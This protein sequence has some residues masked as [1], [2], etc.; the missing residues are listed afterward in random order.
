[1]GLLYIY[2]SSKYFAPPNVKM[3]SP[4]LGSRCSKDSWGI[5][6]AHQ[7]LFYNISGQF[8]HVSCLDLYVWGSH[9]CS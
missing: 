7:I 2:W 9:V 5:C 8:E 6:S 1:M 3:G 4:V